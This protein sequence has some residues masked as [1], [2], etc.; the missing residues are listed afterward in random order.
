MSS[1]FSFDANQFA[2]QSPIFGSAG[3]ELAAALRNLRSVLTSEGR[4]WG[5]DE[6]GEA[7]AHTYS[8]D[9]D[10]TVENLETLVNMLRYTGDIVNH[11][12]KKFDNLDLD[13]A[14]HVGNT[15]T[16][17]IPLA[18]FTPTGSPPAVDAGAQQTVAPTPAPGPAS[19]VPGSSPV[20]A[21]SPAGRDAPSGAQGGSGSQPASSSH[22]APPPSSGTPSSSDSPTGS[23]NSPGSKGTGAPEG[24]A[25]DASSREEASEPP[26]VSVA[27]TS[28][29]A[30]AMSGADP[31]S[32]GPVAAGPAPGSS[33]D[34]SDRQPAQPQSGARPPGGPGGGQQPQ[35]PAQNPRQQR[36]ERKK[37][38]KDKKKPAQ[39]APPETADRPPVVEDDPP[40]TPVRRQWAETLSTPWSKRSHQPGETRNVDA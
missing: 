38:E 34:R 4:C 25:A 24:S 33:G 8:P 5:G 2:G 1:S 20:T 36:R 29:Q 19:T 10:K 3:D 15:G 16:S 28:A 39:V 7:F 18:N 13:T 22:G 9:A 14:A 35:S 40:T 31:E 21:G 11:S 6:P 30:S 12:A 26:R 32:S 37:D 17:A 23:A 27:P